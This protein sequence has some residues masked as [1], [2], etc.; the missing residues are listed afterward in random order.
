M[1]S[2][3]PCQNGYNVYK[4]TLF[5]C[6]YLHD[7]LS[8]HLNG[9]SLSILLYTENDKQIIDL[10]FL[11]SLYPATPNGHDARKGSNVIFPSLRPFSSPHFFYNKLIKAQPEK[12]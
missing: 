9:I 11:S 1:I 6:F 8:L 5:S 10:V 2:R 12:R 7:I 3:L 4:K